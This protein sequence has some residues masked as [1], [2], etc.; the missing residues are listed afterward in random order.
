MLLKLLVGF[1]S[2]FID[3]N[4]K[5]LIQH[6]DFIIMKQHQT[7]IAED[8]ILMTAKKGNTGFF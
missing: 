1:T 6:I 5:R 4:A 2:I 3:T 7:A 8:K